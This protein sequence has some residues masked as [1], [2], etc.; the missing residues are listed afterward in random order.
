MMLLGGRRTICRANTLFN[1]LNVVEGRM[2]SLWSAFRSARFHTLQLMKAH[3]IL[4]AA[5]ES[6]WAFSQHLQ[7]LPLYVSNPLH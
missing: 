5:V 1:H 2:S 7:F 3:F 4:S 6:H